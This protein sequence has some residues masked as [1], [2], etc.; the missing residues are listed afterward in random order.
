MDWEA[1]VASSSSLTSSLATLIFTG[2]SVIVGVIFIFRGVKKIIEHGRGGNPHE[3]IFGYLAINFATGAALLQFAF[4]VQSLSETVFG[5]KMK[6]ASE[7]LSYLP[8]SVKGT[9]MLSAGLDIA[10]MWVSV[11]GMISILRGIILWNS[12]ARG[13]SAREG[14]GWKGFWHIL[15]GVLAA[16]IAGTVALFFGGVA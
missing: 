8:E 1:I 16:N 11:I 6:P 5:E 9:E 12:L 15:F 13:Q 7:A 3:S 4:I 2:V 14:A 10:F